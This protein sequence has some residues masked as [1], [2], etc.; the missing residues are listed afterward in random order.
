MVRGSKNVPEN[1]N[2]GM[3]LLMGGGGVA[4]ENNETI[5]HLKYKGKKV[6]T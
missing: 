1:E 4:G 6:K 3:G 2:S 5:T